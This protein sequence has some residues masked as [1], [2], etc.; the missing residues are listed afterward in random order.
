MRRYGH[1][2][3]RERAVALLV[4]KHGHKRAIPYDGPL[5]PAAA[6]TTERKAKAAGFETTMHETAAGCSLHGVHRRRGVG[7]AAHWHRGKTSGGTW[8]ER[9]ETWKLV[10]ISSRPIGVDQRAKTTKVG[11]RHDAN[12][13][14][15]LVLT[16]SPRGIPLGITELVLGQLHDAIL[17]SISVMPSGMPRGEAVSTSR[18]RSFASW[19]HP[20]FVVFAR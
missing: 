14:T 7:F 15:R 13:R 3:Q 6:R 9:R 2:R 16:A 11:C 8:H 17:L 12:D 20:T 19:R 4:T 5:V 1:E 10:D 18:V